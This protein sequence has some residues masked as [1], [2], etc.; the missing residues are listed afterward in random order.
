MIRLEAEQPWPSFNVSLGRKDNAA[1]AAER[2]ARGLCHR[3]RAH[4]LAV[5]HCEA[6]IRLSRVYIDEF[7]M[8]DVF[9]LL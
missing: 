8:R 4:L 1:I 5:V 7:L 9:V 2:E 3:D 6:F